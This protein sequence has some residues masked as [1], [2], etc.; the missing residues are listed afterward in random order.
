ML[1]RAASPGRPARR[2][3]GAQDATRPRREPI[4]N[5]DNGKC[6]DPKCPAKPIVGGHT[7]GIS[8]KGPAG[9]A[10]CSKG[11]KGK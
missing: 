9:N 10:N 11:G 4:M 6:N 1:R 7:K 2:P 3:T 8:T 5:K